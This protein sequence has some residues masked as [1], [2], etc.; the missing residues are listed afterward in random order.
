MR[1][2]SLVENK[3]LP[4]VQNKEGK[5][6][7]RILCGCLVIYMVMLVSAVT[8][9]ATSLRG[10]F[11]LQVFGGYSWPNA[12]EYNKS[13]NGRLEDLLGR[14]PDLEPW[15]QGE[16]DELKS[17]TIFGVNLKYGYTRKLLV[18][19]G[20]L[21][22][23]GK[24]GLEVTDILDDAEYEGSM[25]EDIETSGITL[26][27][28]YV[29]YDPPGLNLYG[30]IGAGPY[31]SRIKHRGDN[32]GHPYWGFYDFDAEGKDVMGYHGLVGGEYFLSEKFSVNLEAMY[33]SLTIPEFIITKHYEH[34]ECEGEPLFNWLTD[35]KLELDLSGIVLTVS[36]AFW[37]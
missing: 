22:D 31:S 10:R 24:A 18:G 19:L 32:G 7:K 11:G 13:W 12:E 23:S 9:D 14:D 15:D 37:F 3:D 30:G 16:V 5:M 29:F 25:K 17:T 28:Y 6:K 36:V 8:T 26:S 21:K 20:Y 34:P 2:N 33:R 27:L 1:N 35:E 4:R